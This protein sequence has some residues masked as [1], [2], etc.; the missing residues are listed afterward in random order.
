MNH[1]FFINNIDL[2]FSLIKEKRKTL[3][4]NISKDGNL[5][6]KSPLFVKTEEVKNFITKHINWITKKREHN[7][8]FN[9]KIIEE[10]TNGSSFLYLGQKYQFVVEQGLLDE[11]I[12]ENDKMILFTTKPKN[13]QHIKKIIEKWYFNQATEIFNERLHSC[14]C[15]FVG[16]KIPDL[17]IKNMKSRWGSYS[18]KNKITLNSQLI[19]APIKCIDYV[20]IHE[21]C[22]AYH[23]NHGKEFKKLLE[24]KIK[25]WKEIKKKLN[26]FVFSIAFNNE[27]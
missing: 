27:V 12:L 15:N 11:I 25:N 7:K 16:L 24:S 3:S 22:H 18:S 9:T 10:Y 20:V 14:L 4:I 26:F 17:A 13:Q 19:K 2:S 1:E 23:M 21:L 5:I 6:V 8:I